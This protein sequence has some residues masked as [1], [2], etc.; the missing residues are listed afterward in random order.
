MRKQIS[1]GEVKGNG[2]LH[3]AIEKYK[4]VS[5]SSKVPQGTAFF[6]ATQMNEYHHNCIRDTLRA[7]LPISVML[8]KILL[9]FANRSLGEISCD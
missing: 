9:S 8:G 2:Y 7:D 6:F 1:S 5:V 3:F 4:M